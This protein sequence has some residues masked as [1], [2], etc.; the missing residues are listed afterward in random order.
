M[1]LH[2]RLASQRIF[3][4]F[5]PPFQVCHGWEGGASVCVTGEGVGERVR[6]KLVNYRRCTMIMS[7]S[8]VF[9]VL[10]LQQ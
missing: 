10:H 5:F 2:F 7:T 6:L 4:F 3:F 8:H 9:L 1:S